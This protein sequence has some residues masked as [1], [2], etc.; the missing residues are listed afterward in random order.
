[1][2]GLDVGTMQL[3]LSMLLAQVRGIDIRLGV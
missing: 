1:M 2:D 3:T